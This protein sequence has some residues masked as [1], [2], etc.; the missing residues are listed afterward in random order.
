MAMVLGLIAWWFL[1]IFATCVGYLVARIT[2]YRGFR[3]A[4]S[5]LFDDSLVDG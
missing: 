3:R 1:H 2:S 4:C 5:N